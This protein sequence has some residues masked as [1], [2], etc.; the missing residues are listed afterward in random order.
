M[1]HTGG[2]CD[3]EGILEEG[4]AGVESY[5]DALPSP[6]SLGAVNPS[7]FL[8]LSSTDLV[9]CVSQVWGDLQGTLLS[10]WS[11]AVGGCVLAG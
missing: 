6:S 4:W 11:E 3:P 2:G 1:R 8:L 10:R 5:R 7:R 9:Q